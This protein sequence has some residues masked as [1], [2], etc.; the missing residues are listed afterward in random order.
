M[1]HPAQVQLTEMGYPRPA[2]GV[3]L[4]E[5]RNQ[6]EPAAELLADRAP[7]VEA[8]REAGREEAQRDITAAKAETAA[9][10]ANLE[11]H[12]AALRASERERDGLKTENERLKTELDAE[13]SKAAQET[14]IRATAVK[15]AEE[16]SAERDEA[17]KQRDAWWK[18]KQEMDEKLR[19]AE[20]EIDEAKAKIQS[21]E[22]QLAPS[23]RLEVPPPG[24]TQ[25][26]QSAV[27][28]EAGLPPSPIILGPAQAPDAPV[29]A[30]WRLWP[31][32]WGSNKRA[33]TDDTDGTDEE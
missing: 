25:P 3:A 33:R 26:T 21:L 5:T 13:K 2:V 8:G 18:E 27:Y 29:P 17:L 22:A 14:Q 10:E 6:V 7:W 12:K 32:W 24:Q 23:P 19:A 16:R 30:R 31:S 1:V 28:D 9:A 11:R 20:Q 15:H 4:M